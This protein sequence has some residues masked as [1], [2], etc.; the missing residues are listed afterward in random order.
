MIRTAAHMRNAM[1]MLVLMALVTACVRDEEAAQRDR[2]E[3]WFSLGETVEFK[4]ERDCAAA[5]YKVRG[6]GAKAAMPLT[7]SVGEML[8]VLAKRGHAAVA[9][10]GQTPDQSMVMLA[11]LSRDTGMRM[12]RAGLEARACMGEITESAFRHAIETPSAVL[13]FDEASGSLILL[14]PKSGLL[15]VA[16][17]AR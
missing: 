16:M 4:A 8:R 12:R 15:V 11:N 3:Q 7:E 6:G 2:L 10:P 9:R 13:A 14:E 1:S 17:G 5:V